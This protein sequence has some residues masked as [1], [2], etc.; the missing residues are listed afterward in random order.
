MV[1]QPRVLVKALT[2]MTHGHLVGKVDDGCN[3]QALAAAWENE[4]TRTTT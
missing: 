2:Q 4:L 1:A 3:D